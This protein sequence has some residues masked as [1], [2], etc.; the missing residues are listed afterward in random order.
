MTRPASPLLFVSALW[1]ATSLAGSPLAGQSQ[2]VTGRLTVVWD[3]ANG[4]P[5]PAIM[6]T[7]DQGRSWSLQ[8]DS[9]TRRRLGPVTRWA[10]QR[11]RADVAAVLRPQGG[12]LRTA[13]VRSLLPMAALG[14]QAASPP[15]VGAVPWVNLLCKF[16]DVPTY[17]PFPPAV[18]AS[19]MGLT[20]PGAADFFRELSDGVADLSGNAVAGWFVLPAP[21]S[22]YVIQNNVDFTRLLND[23]TAAADAQVDF[24]Q[25][26]GINLQFNQALD[27][28]TTPPYD[29][30]SHGGQSGLAIDGVNRLFGV[31]WL[32]DLHVRNRVVIT[33]EMGHGF[34][35]P[36]SSGPYGQTYDS[37]WD[38]MSAGYLFFDATYGWLGAHTIAYHKDITGW[39]APGQVYA[40]ASR[41]SVR[42]TIER[43]ALPPPGNVRMVRI[44]LQSE[45]GKF[46]TVEARKLAG[47]DRGLPGDALLLHKVD[48]TLGDRQAQVVDPDDNGNPNDDGAMW[49]PGE[50]FHDVA[51]DV[52]LTVLGST[53][54]GY[55]IELE[56]GNAL[57]L[58]AGAASR[59]DSALV[60]D[61]APHADS[62]PLTLRGRNSGAASWA[63]THG[64]GA[65]LTLSTA[66]G[67]GSGMLRWIRDP[68]GLGVGSYIDT[69]TVTAAGAAGSPLRI[70][71]TLEILGPLSVAVTP[72]SHR[73][74]LPQGMTGAQVDSA[75]VLLASFGSDTATWTATHTSAAWLT[76]TGASGIGSGALRWSVIPAGLGSGLYVDTIVVTAAGA[77]GSPVQLI[78]TL[79]VYEPA[80]DLA[81]AEQGLMTG[82][83]CLTPTEREYLDA[84]GNHDQVYN[85]GDLLAYLDR[86]GLA[87]IPPGLAKSPA[88][89]S[90]SPTHPKA[91]PPRGHSP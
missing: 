3:V 5:E 1:L 49:L 43:T 66:A 48:P 45:P 74:S 55:Q 2:S 56:V 35:W 9:A 73:D 34:G 4:G 82:I 91:R 42:L 58:L 14:A 64:S 20:Y 84:T 83:A 79:Q 12:G 38:L 57:T 59:L 52:L 75:A 68:T 71:D 81:C 23:C 31:T 65:W 7:D 32:A 89:E 28:R 54:T 40:T 46:Y 70:L 50:S 44:P 30:L 22:A 27:V 10:G 67:Q 86:K 77:L 19:V 63:A 90:G 21:R 36:H 26:Y 29:Q 78:D 6:L 87:L 11:V 18:V 72:L 25:Y 47:Y 24:S 53:A 60:G 88:V 41:D 39:Y 76:L 33:H 16:A 85:L 62:L 17:E 80:I 37:R 13:R 8:A 15:A 69:I 51:N 61:V